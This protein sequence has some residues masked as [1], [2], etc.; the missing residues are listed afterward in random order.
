MAAISSVTRWDSVLGNKRCVELKATIADTNTYVT[1]LHLIESV[2]TSGVA[3]NQTIAPTAS[4][5]TLTFAV[6]NGPVT[7]GRVFIVGL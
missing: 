7:G 4:G 2:V 6:A 1:G 3:S 5:G